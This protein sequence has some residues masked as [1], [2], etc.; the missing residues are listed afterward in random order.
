MIRSQKILFS[1]ILFLLIQA[2]S[3]AQCVMCS[4][5]IETNKIDGG[6]TGAGINA[7]VGYLS[8]FPYLILSF[9]GFII[10][11]VYKKDKEQQENQ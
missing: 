7:G 2:N 4:A 3:F 5:T 8:F 9:F 6:N 11:K 1:T 10:Y